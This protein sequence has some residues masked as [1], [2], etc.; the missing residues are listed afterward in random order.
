MTMLPTI[1]VGKA[2][3]TENMVAEI[4]KQLKRHGEVRV[5]LLPGAGEPEQRRELVE[6]LA[7]KVGAV[8][9]SKVGF[10]VV[11]KRTTKL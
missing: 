3:L 7:S 6:G 9:T 11:L 5:K 2:G 8:V 1:N 4:Q 10:V